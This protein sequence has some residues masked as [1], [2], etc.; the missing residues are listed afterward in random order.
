MNLHILADIYALKGDK[1]RAARIYR[2]ILREDS[3]DKVAE[4]SLR[5]LATK[6]VDVSGIN[7]E[8][9]GFFIRAKTKDEL[10]E[11][12]RWLVGD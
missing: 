1:A 10:D 6:G 3:G 11:V 12:E 2:H 4:D 8:I 9:C 5:R 7:A